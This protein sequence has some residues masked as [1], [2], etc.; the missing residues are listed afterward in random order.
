MT[1]VHNKDRISDIRVSYIDSDKYLLG[2]KN[3]FKKKK[4]NIEFGCLC[5][6]K[7]ACSKHCTLYGRRNAK[8][9]FFKIISADNSTNNDGLI[10][11]CK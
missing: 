7:S 10:P 2:K 8:K 1:V 6:K 5:Y 11:A 3:E 9:L 4:Q